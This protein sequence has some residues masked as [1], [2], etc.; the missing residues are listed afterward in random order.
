[1][2]STQ[3]SSE[4]PS[5]KYMEYGGNMK[6]PVNLLWFLLAIFAFSG[7]LSAQQDSTSYKPSVNEINLAGPRIGVSYLS[8]RFRHRLE[9]RYSTS[10]KSVIAQFGWHFERRFFSVTSGLSALTEWIFLIGGFEQEKFL[11]SLTWLLGIRL[12][13]GIEFGAGPNIALSGTSAVLATGIT[14]HTDEIN[15]PINVAVSTSKSGPRY[16][17]LFGFNLRQNEIT[18]QKI[19]AIEKKQ[20]NH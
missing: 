4:S 18:G 15:F 6:N 5:R 16:T 14:L 20:Y 12:P 13:N 3:Q 11:P 9:D 19:K 2:K 17:L 8:D 1:M 10:L 7:M